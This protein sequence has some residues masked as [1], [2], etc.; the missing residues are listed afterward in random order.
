MKKIIVTGLLLATTFSAVKCQEFEQSDVVQ[1]ASNGPLQITELRVNS[2]E[3]GLYE[4]FE[5]TFELSGEWDN[6]FDPE[7]IKV[8]ARF[9]SPDGEELLVPGFF[10]QKYRRKENG[11]LKKVGEPVWKV[12]FTPVQTGEYQY[13]VI[14]NNNGEE[15]TSPLQEFQSTSYNANHGF[16]RV[17]EINPHYFEYSDGM[18]F[19][20]VA[21][22]RQQGNIYDRKSYKRFSDAGGNFN[23]LFLTN[24]GLNLGELNS[25]SRPDRGL[26]KMNL[27]ASWRL[28]QVLK[29]GEK[30]GI[31]HILT[32]TNQWTFNHRWDTHA[33]N[34][35]NGGILDSPR[36]YWTDEEAM[37]YFE[38]H[39]RYLVAR[40]G[41]S[42]SV[43]SWDLWNE[44]TA[45]SGSDLEVAIPWHRRMARYISSI[46]VFD[47]IIHTNDGSLN[48]RDRMHALPE[49]DVVSTNT[50]GVK[51]IAHVAEVWTKRMIGKFNKPYVLSEVGPGHG[52]GNYGELDP[53]R[54][55][56]HNAL[57]SPLVSGS[58]STGMAW[59]GSWLGHHT[60]YTYT[61]GI[62]EFVEG[63]PFSK[64][65]WEP[66]SV[67]SFTFNDP[68][69][70]NPNYAD[71]LVEGW[72]GNFHMSEEEAMEQEFFRIDENGHV[73]P[74]ELL[75][76][77]LPGP[78]EQNTTWLTAPNGLTSSV[79]FRAEYPVDG[80]FVV[81][82]TELRDTEPTPQL[83]VTLDGKQVLQKDLS[84]LETE[85]YRPR[86]FNQ[87]YTIDISRG[88]H[89]VRI[90]NSGGGSFATAFELK[91][92]IPKNGPDLEVRGLQSNDFILLW[93]K[94]QKFTILHEMMGIDIKPQPEGIL[95]LQNVP[96][97]IWLVEWMNT[98]DAMFFK[99]ELVESRDQTL[100]L[101]TPVIGKSIAIR[102]HKI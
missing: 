54:R 50:Y 34:I 101:E 45:M 37:Q 87:Y 55:M 69:I 6:P 49:I 28:D 95:E 86:R 29:A 60:F 35:E 78:N 10:F 96:D 75:S 30:L 40:W 94:N 81:Y 70:P 44:Y 57:W 102:L 26:G 12:R 31:Y 2:D 32:I 4:K 83:T 42:P 97:G 43:F 23:R 99:T 11:D 36:E 41:Y 79:T 91:N 17:S 59:E 22:G 61:R 90:E 1:L 13:Q 19:F 48:G 76:A 85:D 63:I 15:I 46:D 38:R 100:V 67:A 27:V 72:V 18:P 92:Y 73:H 3:I 68:D 16:I 56:V 65:Q 74:Q 20:G 9:T 7:Q 71:V 47:H 64:L 52:I 21:M 84:P 53:E 25:T 14:V 5:I 89:T 33:Y 88:S 77:V 51:N 58:A 82:V 8:G 98:T 62:S 39:L 66:V 24:G 93:L 80:E